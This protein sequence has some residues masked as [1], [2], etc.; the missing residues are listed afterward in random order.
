MNSTNE[1]KRD[2]NMSDA[3]MLQQVRL[4]LNMKKEDNDK[5]VAFDPEFGG[6]YDGDAQVKINAAETIVKNS[7]SLSVQRQLTEK[8]DE[9]MI[10]CKNKFKA[11]KY[12]IEKAFPGRTTVWDEFGYGDYRNADHSQQNM[13][14]FMRSLLRVV[15]KYKPEL[16]AAGYTDAMITE[17]TSSADGIEQTT[18]DQG[19]YIKGR[20]VLTSDRIATLNAAFA[21]AHRIC[22]AGKI[23]FV[24]DSVRAHRYVIYD[25]GNHPTASKITLVTN[26]TPLKPVNLQVIGATGN[27]ITVDFGDGMGNKIIFNN[28][29]QTETHNYSKPW[30]YDINITGNVDTLVKFGMPS[31]GINSITLPTSGNEE[32]IEI[33]LQDNELTATSINALLQTID[34]YGTY[35]GTI[36]LT[37]GSNAAPTGDGI[38]AMQKLKER[39][40]TVETN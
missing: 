21:V 30:N 37:G 29:L 33:S 38:T 5:F 2:Y 11:L 14:L 27:N 26:Q 20:P 7:E 6:T 1:L 12:F 24:N 18:I 40:W 10:L 17:L 9:Q 32:L 34:S 4:K 22:D 8:V 31:S 16:L 35:N 39:M 3:Q 23:I 25:N 36:H 15:D 19:L 13:V 28:Q